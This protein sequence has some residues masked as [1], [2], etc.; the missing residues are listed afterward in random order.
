M[1]LGNGHLEDVRNDQG[2]KPD[3]RRCMNDGA[4]GHD[5]VVGEAFSERREGKLVGDGIADQCRDGYE[6]KPE[7]YDKS[8]G[9]P[10]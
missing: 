10:D 9:Q 6:G 8:D 4:G 7:S 5:R 3:V 2:N 1:F